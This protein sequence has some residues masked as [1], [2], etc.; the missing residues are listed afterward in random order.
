[1]DKLP[2]HN[3][4]V[5]FGFVWKSIQI[6][7]FLL[8]KYLFHCSKSYIEEKLFVCH[9]VAVVCHLRNAGVVEVISFPP[10]SSAPHHLVLLERTLNEPRTCLKKNQG[11][12][13]QPSPEAIII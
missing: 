4:I 1:M 5:R 7:I 6:L 11:G 8:Y 2:L 3:H 13:A 9:S 12:R 10:A